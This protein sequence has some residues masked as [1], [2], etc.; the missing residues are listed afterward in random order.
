MADLQKYIAEISDYSSPV[1]EKLV[2][3]LYSSLASILGDTDAANVACSDEK[4][5]AVVKKNFI[6]NKLGVEDEDK[7]DKA[8]AAVCK[9]MDGDRTKNR[10]VFYYL[11]TVELDC[12]KKLV[13]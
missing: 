12:I 4:E 10:L 9:L 11:V 3:T 7:A 13:K 5:L 1:N 2:E 6:V 8:I